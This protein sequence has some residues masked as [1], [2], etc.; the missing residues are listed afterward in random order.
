MTGWD[1]RPSPVR[2]EIESSRYQGGQLLVTGRSLAG[3]RLEDMLFVQP[4]GAASRPPKG[5]IGIA[6]PM[7]GRRAQMLVMGIEHGEKRPDLPDGAAALYDA[8]GNI[9][10][11]TAGGVTMNFASRTVTMTAGTWNIAGNVTIDGTL[12]VTGNITSDSAD[13]ADE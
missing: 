10:L 9:V 13:A 11:L 3:E 5:A 8:D 2:F 1:R 4:H 12:H 7:P 6:Q